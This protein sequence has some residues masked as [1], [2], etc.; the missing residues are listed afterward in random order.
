MKYSQEKII[1]ALTIIIE[2]CEENRGCNTCPFSNQGK[3][4]VSSDGTRPDEWVLNETKSWK[5][6][7]I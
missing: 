5:A 6:I 7:I 2:T 4:L 1:E 3:C